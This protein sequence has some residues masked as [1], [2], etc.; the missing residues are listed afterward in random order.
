V[1]VALFMAEIGDK[2]QL[3]TIALAVEYITIL[4]VW[5]ETTI[6]T[7]ISNGFGIMAGM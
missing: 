3:A 4:P 5:M 6:G 2:S 1:T 7:I